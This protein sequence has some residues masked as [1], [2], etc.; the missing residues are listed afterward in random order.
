MTTVSVI[1]GAAGGMGFACAKA[2]A[3][4]VDVL[5]LT[6]RNAERLLS[7]A[8]QIEKAT[9]T[10]VTTLVGD[11][12]DIDLIAELARKAAEIGQFH[13]LIHTAGVSPNM[14][15]W[16]EVFR[17]DLASTQLLLDEFAKNV[18]PGSVAI[19]LASIAGQLGAFD[20]AIDKVLD[21]PLAADFEEQLQ[22]LLHTKPNSSIAYRLAKRGVIRLCE[23]AGAAWGKH[24]GRVLSVSPGLI[25]TEMGRLEL[26]ESPGKARMVEL[27]PIRSAQHDANAILPGHTLDIAETIAFLCSSKASFISGCDIRID[28]GLVGALNHS[29]QNLFAH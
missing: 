28:G 18:V 10:A 6:D 7:A 1:T 2:I 11:I 9:K 24:G 29:K 4:A 3:A 8:A 21:A 13:S 26:K 12:A 19:C 17:V 27:T 22:S 5:L 23:R 25:D 14:A 16:H 20:A 15:D